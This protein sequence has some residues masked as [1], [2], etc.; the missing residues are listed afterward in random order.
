V[1]RRSSIDFTKST[2]TIEH[3]LPQSMTQEWRE[4]L[5][6]EL[7]GDETFE[8]LHA[9][10]VHTLGNL[11]LTAY[12]GKLANDG[13]ATKQQILADSGLA[14]NHEIADSPRWGAKEIRDRGRALAERALPIWPGPDR[15]ADTTP[16]ETRWWRMNQILACI[17]AGR[18]TSY[19]EVAEVI[20]SHHMP[21]G[22]RLGSATVPNGHRV[23]RFSGEISPDF[24]WPDPDRTDDPLAVV[25][26][27]GV[28]FDSKRRASAD[29]RLTAVELAAFA[30]LDVDVPEAQHQMDA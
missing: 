2:L 17:P 3:V 21:V 10:L 25:Q 18:W 5:T 6:Q 8:E 30:D 9:K 16:I 20:G 1:G 19:S 22:A 26:A 24:R 14:M 4:M 13:F 27:E 12:N 7:T 23:L 28:R 29:Q 11:S 15:S